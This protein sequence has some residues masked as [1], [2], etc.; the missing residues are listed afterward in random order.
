MQEGT[1]K[2][3]YILSVFDNKQILSNMIDHKATQVS[4]K[5]F[6][7]AIVYYNIWMT[8]TNKFDGA[9]D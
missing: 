1:G 8:S 6:Y 7:P 2:L 5:I 3:I 4:A 9:Y